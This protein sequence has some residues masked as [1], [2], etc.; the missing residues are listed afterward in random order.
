MSNDFQ[1]IT[2]KDRYEKQRKS[3][4]AIT[5][6]S[7]AGGVFIIIIIAMVVFGG[8]EDTPVAVGDEEE[9]KMQEENGEEESNNESSEK[10]ESDT[11]LP[12]DR[13]SNDENESV[14]LNDEE[15]GQSEEQEENDTT[16]NQSTEEAQTYQ[17]ES[18]DENVSNAYEGNWEPVGTEQ[19]GPHTIQFDKESVDWEEM[20]QAVEVAT[21]IPTEEQIVWWIGRSGKQAVE[22]TISPSNNQNETFRVH[23]SWINEKG[24]QPTLVEELIENDVKENS[25]D[26]EE[27]NDTEEEQEE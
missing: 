23:L 1:Q 7:V 9:N 17:V 22:A 12:E 21:G 25:S 3:T 18:D 8:T 15:A 10:E 13:E 14:G 6:L 24:W 2:R 20:L 11:T 5:W 19:T 4:K 16:N 27:T 26:S